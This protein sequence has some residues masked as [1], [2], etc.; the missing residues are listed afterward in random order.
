MNRKK[1]EI[2]IVVGRRRH[3]RVVRVL[4]VRCFCASLL[5]VNNIAE[6]YSAV[7]MVPPSRLLFLRAVSSSSSSQ[8]LLKTRQTTST[9]KATSARSDTSNSILY[10]RHSYPS[11]TMMMMMS[12]HDDDDNDKT[13]NTIDQ[14]NFDDNTIRR[15]TTYYI[16]IITETDACDTRQ[17]MEETYVAIQQAVSTGYVTLV[18]IRLEKIQNKIEK[19]E[20]QQGE[21][22]LNDEQTNEQELLAIELT[23]KLVQLSSE[24]SSLSTKSKSNSHRASS[25]H[26][27]S[28]SFHVV[29]SSDWITVAL[30]GGAHGVHFKEKH[31]SMIPTLRRN[32]LHTT[33]KPPKPILIGTSTHSIESAIQSY[34]KYQPDYYFVGTCYLTQSHP[35]KTSTDELEGPQLPGQVKHAIT[36]L[37]LNGPDEQQQQ[38][39][40]QQQQEEEV[41]PLPPIPIIYAIGGINDTNCFEPVQIYGADGVAVIRY[42]LAATDPALAVTNLHTNMLKG[43]QG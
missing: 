34:T 35:E 23:K 2:F 42:V 18:S 21:E 4:L 15:N 25:L 31:L 39:Q 22:E 6:G 8:S 17:R 29:C 28:R 9:T 24:M 1:K 37:L 32:L 14:K 3:F 33:T 36:K 19:L 11:I 43:Y 7:L 20:N 13:Y 12:K 38:Q 27:P 40:Q 5:A 10:R 41:K 30:Q 16:A 26:S